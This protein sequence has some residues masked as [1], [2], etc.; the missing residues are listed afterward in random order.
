MSRRTQN[1]NEVNEVPK[2]RRRK[3]FSSSDEESEPENGDK[4]QVDQID[5]DEEML[6]DVSVFKVFLF[7]FSIDISYLY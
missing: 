7:C 1:M 6:D 3:A 5:E 2:K 4:Q